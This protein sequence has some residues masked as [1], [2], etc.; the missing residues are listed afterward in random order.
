MVTKYLIVPV[1]AEFTE[2]TAD[3]PDDALCNFALVMDSD[4]HTFFRA[5]PADGYEGV[6]QEAKKK[7]FLQWAEEK[8]RSDFNKNAD[9]EEDM[10]KEEDIAGVANDAW[11]NYVDSRG[12]EYHC[13]EIAVDDYLEEED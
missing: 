1:L 13:I 9:C 7:L 6:L 10:V 11:W 12:T 3:S 8:I 2:V 4:M 5:V